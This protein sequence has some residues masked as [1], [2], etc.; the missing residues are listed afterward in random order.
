MK[1]IGESRGGRRGARAHLRAVTGNEEQSV[2]D[3]FEIAVILP[4]YN[5]EV[6]IGRTV[7]DFRAALPMARIYVFDNASTDRTAE[8]ARAAGAIVERE[9]RAGK[10]NVVRRMFADVNADI[11]VL[12]DGDATYD[13]A[14]APE[15]IRRLVDGKLDM[16]AGARVSGETGAYRRGHRLGNRLLT[17]LVHRLFS[18]RFDDM[19]TGYRVFSRRFVKSF[20][21]ASQG[22]EI[23]TELTV[24]ALYM[25]LPAEEVQTRYVSRP[26]DSHSKLSTYA[27]GWRILRMIGFLLKEEKPMQFFSLLALAAF[28][29][30]AFVFGSVFLEFMETGLVARFPSLIVAVAGMILS[31]MSLVCGV[32]LDTVARGRREARYMSYLQHDALRA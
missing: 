8:V 25:R 23:E 26:E 10:G 13:A 22:F 14:S 31:M 16:V 5:E 4:C 18:R 29:P 11:Y 27:D 6:A 17:G 3:Q 12:A 7:E 2:L 28:L 21:A 32:I 19:L 30:S 20:P 15:M 1:D 9:P 24:H